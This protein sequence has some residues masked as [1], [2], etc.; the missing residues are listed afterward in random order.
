MWKKN[1]KL[2]QGPIFKLKKR[3]FKYAL[4]YIKNH[5]NTMRKDSLTRKLHDNDVDNFWKE[6]KLI[7]N[8]SMPLPMNIDGVVGVDKITEIWRKHYFDLF[9]CIR[10]NLNNLN[11]DVT[12]SNDMI[13]TANE[14]RELITKL[15]KKACGQS[16]LNT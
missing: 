14:F 12:F 15:D 7:N 4:C 8:N 5:E 11:Y 13:V 16:Q 1:G 2:K 6:V 10:S 9:N 3:R